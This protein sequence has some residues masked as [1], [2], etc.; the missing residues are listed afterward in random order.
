MQESLTP[1]MSQMR[2]LLCVSSM[3]SF[4]DLCSVVHSHHTSS[5]RD[6]NISMEV[7]RI[8][9]GSNVPVHFTETA[10]SLKIP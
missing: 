8:Y 2:V 3:S 5:S 7:P 9:R 6:I 1:C 10:V 4:H